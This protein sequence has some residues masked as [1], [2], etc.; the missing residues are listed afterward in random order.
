MIRKASW[1]SL[2]LCYLGLLAMP[3]RQSISAEPEGTMT[4]PIVDSKMSEAEAFD[5]LD[6]QCPKEIREQQKVVTVLYWGFDKKVHRG[7]IVL[8][9]NLEKDVVE[10]FEVALKQKFPIHS[11]IP[12]AHPAF[13]KDHS[14]SDDLSMAANNTSSFN[15]RPVTGKK[16]LSNHAYGWA[17]D[18]NPLQNPYIKGDV[19]LP[20]VAKY[21]VEAEGTLTADH[22]I[23]KAFLDRGWKWGGNWKSPKDYQHFEKP[24]KTGK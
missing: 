9:K 7:Q 23:T 2:S 11:V 17:I 20:P 1:L 12:M 16:T 5:G 13:R 24:I 8:D 21:N 6:P 19:I 3:L 10:V 14:W 15:Y 4:D 18:I 22:A